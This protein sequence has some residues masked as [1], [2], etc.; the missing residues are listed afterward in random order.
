MRSLRQFWSVR[1]IH[2]NRVNLIRL[3]PLRLWLA[4]T[5]REW[6]YAVEHGDENEVMDI[7]QVPE[8]VVPKNLEWTSTFFKKAPMEFFLRPALP[9][10]PL[11][12]HPQ[13]SVVIPDGE[14][15]K[16]YILIP[17]SLEMVVMVDEHEVVLG[18]VPSIGLSD[19]W[20]GSP[21]EGELCYSLPFNA[22]NSQ[23]NLDAM[24]FQIVWPVEIR[25]QS[26]EDLRFEKLCLRPQNVGLYSGDTHLWSS[27]VRI[28]RESSYRNTTIKYGKSSPEEEADLMELTQ[29]QKRE[30]RIFSRLT[31][32]TRFKRDTIF[33]N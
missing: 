13:C 32:G 29:P 16:F 23:Q 18:S 3:G 26:T 2:E 4:R 28:T 8:D 15:A 11:V 5:E 19:T 7:A 25:N 14:S 27:P 30:D 20:F 9:D 12:V 33:G 31:F 17:A 22:E 24:P 21:I 1:R 6:V 10:R